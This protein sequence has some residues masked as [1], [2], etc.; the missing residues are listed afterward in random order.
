M[1]KLTGRDKKAVILS[2]INDELI[3]Q[4]YPPLNQFIKPVMVED[5]EKPAI[6]HLCNPELGVLQLPMYKYQVPEYEPDYRDYGM[7][8]YDT[9]FEE[10][11]VYFCPYCQKV[12]ILSNNIY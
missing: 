6:R 10:F 1:R 4:G 3:K 7:E 11:T 9:G 5:E 12:F 8:A 2:Y